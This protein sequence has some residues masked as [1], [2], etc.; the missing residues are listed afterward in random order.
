MLTRALAVALLA[1]ATGCEDP[2]PGAADG[3]AATWPL[4]DDWRSALDPEL[5]A[6]IDKHAGR[7]DQAPADGELHGTL[8]LVY[9]ANRMWPEAARAF[10]QARR[11][12]PES[13]LWVSHLADAL[14]ELAEGERALELL[15]A[16]RARHGDDPPLL[17]RLGLAR[18]EAGD[19]EQAAELF[20]RVAALAPRS[21]AGHLG[22]G[23]AALEL[24]RPAEA[25]RALRAALER[26]P[27][28]RA[29]HYLLGRALR[30][31][32][33]TAEALTHLERGSGGALGPMS[34]P[35]DRKLARFAVGPE[36]RRQRATRALASGQPAEALALLEPLARAH[37]GDARLWV[38]LGVAY[39]RS[40]RPAEA[41]EAF[42]EAAALD[43]DSHLVHANRAACLLDLGRPAEALEAAERTLELAPELAGGHVMR[44]MAQ[45]ALGNDTAARESLDRARAL[46]PEDRQV[47][48]AL[49]EFEAGR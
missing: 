35:A 43:P 44:A 12:A 21:P 29:A 15:E 4:A 19:F 28:E 42:G 36:F 27:S 33:R 39:S 47:Q 23:A 5:V 7:V 18:L 10:E 16:G 25:E 26:D 22:L 11:L 31:Q 37:P 14:G 41:L 46:A 17:H 45:R 1:C 13:P 49:A 24:D 8:G 48:R 38:D 40:G 34:D 32:G 9:Q 30:A 3:S 20:E 6:L 2:P